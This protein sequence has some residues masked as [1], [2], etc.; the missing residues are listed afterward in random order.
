M[1]KDLVFLINVIEKFLVVKNDNDLLV[2]FL[3]LLV[4]C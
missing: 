1:D 4:E 2:V 3:L